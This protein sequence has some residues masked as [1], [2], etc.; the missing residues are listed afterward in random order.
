[1]ESTWPHVALLMASPRLCFLL[2]LLQLPQGLSSPSGSIGGAFMFLTW[3]SSIAGKRPVLKKIRILLRCDGVP[4]YGILVPMETDSSREPNG[5]EAKLNFKGPQ[6]PKQGTLT[7]DRLAKNWTWRR[8]KLSHKGGGLH[9]G[10]TAGD[11]SCLCSVWQQEIVWLLTY[12]Q[13]KCHLS[14]KWALWLSLC[15]CE[16]WKT[17]VRKQVLRESLN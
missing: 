6:K 9:M 1:M 13:I 3:L 11:T 12:R 7:S 2:W 10:R 16:R 8:S 14:K 4:W 15:S 17:F 5:P